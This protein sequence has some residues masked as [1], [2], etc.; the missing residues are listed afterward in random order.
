MEFR[1]ILAL[2]LG[3]CLAAQAPRRVAV[4]AAADLKWALEEVR[5]D[6]AKDSPGIQVEVSFGSSG[7]FYAQLTQKAPFDLFLSADLDYA[8]K[9]QDA[10]LGRSLFTY[11]V[12]RLAMVVPAESTLDL[13]KLGLKALLDPS[14]KHV[15]MANPAHAPYGRAAQAAL[16]AAGLTAQVQ[17]KLVL[18]ENVSQAAQFVHTR[19]AEAGLVALSLAMAPEMAGRCRTWVVP[20]TLHPP[21]E[22]G[23]VVLA[24]ARDPAAAEAFRAFLAGPRGRAILARYGFEPP[25]S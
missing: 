3:L 2:C 24:W 20:R 9:L 1:T 5:R 22:Q 16:A 6:F 18:G 11:A 4:A 12:G 15:A 19:A 7:Q 21:L 14:V 23:G 25:S 13:D 10:G 17:P 8:R